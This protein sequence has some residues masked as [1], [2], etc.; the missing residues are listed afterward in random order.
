L[1]KCAIGWRFTN[2]RGNRNEP[3]RSFGYN[4]FLDIRYNTSGAQTA[5]S[6][7]NDV[8]VYNSTFLVT[9]N[10]G[11]VDSKII[12]ME[13]NAE[14][15][16]NELHFYGEENGSG[17]YLL[18]ITSPKNQ[19]T[20][21]GDINFPG[22]A[23]NIV[24]GAVVTRW[25]DSQGYFNAVP[26]SLGNPLRSTSNVIWNESLDLASGTDLNTITACGYYEG[27]NFV[28]SPSISPSTALI[29][30]QVVCGGK[31]GA[32][33]LTQIAYQG[34]YTN[35]NNIVWQRTRDNGAWGK[36]QAMPNA[37]SVTTQS[38]SVGSATWTSGPSIPNGKCVTGSLYSNSSGGAGTTLYVCINSQWEDLK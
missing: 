4:R 32:G 17:G 31:A 11:G 2:R 22:V 16:E 6:F 19:F 14:F 3:R 23:N 13:G 34:N 38:L 20:F 15:Y 18:D 35:G 27:A 37:L 24:A 9:G 5:F 12:H 26:S 29:H 36:W 28:N 21:T 7:E 1:Y 25:L 33:Y 8:Y 30:L 10:K